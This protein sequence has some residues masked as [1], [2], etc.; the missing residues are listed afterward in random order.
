MP[1]WKIHSE[2]IEGEFRPAIFID[3]DGVLISDCHY[4]SNPASVEI[5]PGVTEALVKARNAGFLLIGVT[6]QSGIGRGFFDKEDFNAV[7]EQLEMLLAQD[8]AYLDAFFYCPHA[9][10]DACQCRKPLPGM[11]NEANDVFKWD[12]KG[13]WVVGDKTSDVALGRNAQ[14]GGALVKTGYGEKETTKVLTTWPND[15]LVG[16]FDDLAMAVDHI[17]KQGC[18][19]EV[20]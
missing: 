10:G 19:G 17:L 9:P 16:V 7:M 5:L 8:G 1:L 15:P 4:L 18:A 14:L 11:L 2:L 3:R 6:N 13:S 20:L 12:K